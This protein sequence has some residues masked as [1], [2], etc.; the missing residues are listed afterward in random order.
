MGHTPEWTWLQEAREW[1]ERYITLRNAV[2]SFVIAYSTGS[3][4]DEAF[5]GQRLLEVADLKE[6]LQGDVDRV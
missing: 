2:E 3:L 6:Y 1:R 5:A 4:E